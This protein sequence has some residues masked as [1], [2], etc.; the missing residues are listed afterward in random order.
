[1]DDDLLDLISRAARATEA[2]LGHMRAGDESRP[3]PCPEM[4][5]AAGT[6]TLG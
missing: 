2:V 3:T 4:D 5:V 1:M 6:V